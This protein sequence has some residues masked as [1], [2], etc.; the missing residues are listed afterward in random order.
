ML[1]L[2]QSH[3]QESCIP[4]GQAGTISLSVVHLGH[5][6][7]LF[8]CETQGKSSRACWPLRRELLLP[9]LPL[10]FRVV[11]KLGGLGGRGGVRCPCSQVRFPLEG[12][13]CKQGQNGCQTFAE[14]WLK[15]SGT[16]C[17][18]GQASAGA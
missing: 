6:R 13:V 15:P 11:Q 17:W 1:L 5:R 8:T 4:W 3:P 14:V 16:P 10:A 7:S 2:G 9:G 18:R 12:V